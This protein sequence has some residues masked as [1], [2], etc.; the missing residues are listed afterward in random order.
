MEYLKEN[1]GHKADNKR[2]P[3]W[4]KNL[5]VKYLEILLKALIFG[6]GSIIKHVHTTNYIYTTISEDLRL[7]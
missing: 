3:P 5:P 1:I 6:D 2:I 4:I 7:K